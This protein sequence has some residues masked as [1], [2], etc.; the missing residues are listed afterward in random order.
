MVLFGFNTQ[1]GIVD[2]TS[3]DRMEISD[4]SDIKEREENRISGL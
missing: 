2:G 3:T 4:L 1:C